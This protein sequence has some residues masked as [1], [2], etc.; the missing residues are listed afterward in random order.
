MLLKALCVSVTLRFAVHTG[1][2][3]PKR[4]LKYTTTLLK[5]KK[6]IHLLK[7]RI[8]VFFVKNASTVVFL[9]ANYYLPKKRVITLYKP[10]RNFK[11]VK[12]FSL[13]K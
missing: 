12:E 9:S 3:N 11:I 10:D 2:E 7:K 1:K 4:I 5:T 6:L 13:S 8:T